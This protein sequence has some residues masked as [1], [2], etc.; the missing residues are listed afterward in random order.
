[1]FGC[2]G[3]LCGGLRAFWGLFS[4]S[5][6]FLLDTIPVAHDLNP[7]LKCLKYDG[8][9]ILVGLLTPIEPAL[10][11]GLLVVCHYMLRNRLRK[12]AEPET[13]EAT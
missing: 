12:E 1:M 11:A 5:F 7:Y 13:A 4:D 6:D 9:H 10:Q 2:F 8:T 3:M